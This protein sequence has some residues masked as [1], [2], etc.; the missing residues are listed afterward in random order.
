MSLLTIAP[1]FAAVLVILVVIGIGAQLLDRRRS[2]R[3]STVSASPP[4][5]PRRGH[6]LVLLFCFAAFALYGSLIPFDFISVGFEDALKRFTQILGSNVGIDSRSDCVANILLAFPLGFCGAAALGADKRGAARAIWQAALVIGLCACYSTGLEFLQLWTP[7]RT[8]SQNDIAAQTVGAIAGVVLWNVAGQRMTNWARRFFSNTGSDQ[9]INTLLQAYSAILFIYSVLPLD[10]TISP[11]QLYH[12]IHDHLDSMFVP[13][14]DEFSAER[15]ANTLSNAVMFIAVGML[16][17]SRRAGLLSRRPILSATLWGF[18]LATAIEL[19]QLFVLSRY[20]KLSDVIVGTT[21]AALGGCLRLWI[22]PGSR[23]AAEALAASAPQRR[24]SSWKWFVLAAM[25]TICLFI[26]FLAPFQWLDDPPRIAKRWRNLWNIPFGYSKYWSDP[27]EALSDV[28]LKLI[29][30]GILGAVLVHCFASLQA[31]RGGES[32]GRAG[33]PSLLKPR[34]WISHGLVLA[35]VA[36]LAMVIEMLQVYFPP[37]VADCTDALLATIGAGLG[38]LAVTRV[39]PGRI[40][41]R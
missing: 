12:K 25:Y 3:A 6:Y 24:S 7:G 35:T 33:K 8:S 26:I 11:V 20:T 29:L 9:R 27:L 1:W 14:G 2:M 17:A 10:I 34:R 28:M 23:A 32:T 38:L 39:A 16:T 19:A 41:S 15:I 5:P 40:A 37:H 13:V 36:G 31:P 22:G 18:C 4:A 30:F 21:A